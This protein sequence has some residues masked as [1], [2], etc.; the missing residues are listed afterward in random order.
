MND[1]EG[2][3][4]K[5]AISQRRYILA[6][7]RELIDAALLVNSDDSFYCEPLYIEGFDDAHEKALAVLDK[8]IGDPNV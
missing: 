2:L 1:D 5:Y 3:V 6:R 7:A 8:L 4:R